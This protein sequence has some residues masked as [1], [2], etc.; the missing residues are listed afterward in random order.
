MYV[1]PG[2]YSEQKRKKKRIYRAALLLMAHTES[3]S[4]DHPSK[5]W[6][7]KL[8]DIHTIEYH[9]AVKVTKPQ[10]HTSTGKTKETSPIR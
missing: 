10:I 3:N 5:I 6:I 9:T 1:C 8:W 4:H 7:N 2:E